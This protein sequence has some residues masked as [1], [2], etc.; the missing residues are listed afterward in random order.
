MAR[1]IPAVFRL[2]LCAAVMTGLAGPAAADDHYFAIEFNGTVIGYVHAVT[3]PLTHGGRTVTL[4][5]HEMVVRGTLLGGK[6]DNRLVL[7][8]HLDPATNTFTYHESRIEQGPSTL[9]SA[10]RIDGRTARVSDARR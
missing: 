5:T 3:A 8:Y 10:I 4:L 9:T 2:V 1:K 7:T 6:V